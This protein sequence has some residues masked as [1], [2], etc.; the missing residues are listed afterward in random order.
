M[1]IL[2]LFLAVSTV[3]AQEQVS[4]IGRLNAG[5]TED[6]QFN[7]GVYESAVNGIVSSVH[8]GPNRTVSHSVPVDKIYGV[9]VRVHYHDFSG[10]ECT[11]ASRS[12]IG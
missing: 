3:F 5:F 10:T 1:L 11:P 12:A 8:N 4:G 6:V 7:L 9:N 2:G